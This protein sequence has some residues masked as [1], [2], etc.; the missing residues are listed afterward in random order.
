MLLKLLLDKLLL[1]AI[2]DFDVKQIYQ[3]EEMELDFYMHKI[4][5]DENHVDLR[6]IYRSVNRYYSDVVLTLKKEDQMET[7]PPSRIG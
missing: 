6:N 1:R 2:R 7:I 5:S 4:I 3:K